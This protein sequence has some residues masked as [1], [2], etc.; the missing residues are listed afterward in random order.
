MSVGI[1]CELFKSICQTLSEI[2]LV[3]KFIFDPSCGMSILNIDAYNQLMIDGIISLPNFEW[4]HVKE[5][6]EC[7]LYLTGLLDHIAKFVP[8]PKHTILH[9]YPQTGII[10][11]TNLETKEIHETFNPSP[12]MKPLKI[13]TRQLQAFSDCFYDYSC[14]QIEKSMIKLLLSSAISDDYMISLGVK[15]GTVDT[16]TSVNKKLTK[17]QSETL[18]SQQ[19]V[20][21]SFTDCDGKTSK[22]IVCQ[23]HHQDRQVLLQQGFEFNNTV[24]TKCEQNEPIVTCAFSLRLF[25]LVWRTAR[26]FETQQLKQPVTI[27]L[28]KQYGLLY[29]IHIQH[30]GAS[31][32]TKQVK[33][34][35]RYRLLH[36]NDVD[37]RLPHRRHELPTLM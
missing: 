17:E 23:P 34:F 21:F 20:L 11:C 2:V 10:K 13:S 5:R 37:K 29:V 14:V 24:T 19:P 22:Q 30:Y 8:Q 6:I 3:S 36:I 16:N 7:S 27:G 18:L 26:H 28:S 9:I 1:N 4:F 31:K 32:N 35:I 12:L 15:T 33:S 25:S